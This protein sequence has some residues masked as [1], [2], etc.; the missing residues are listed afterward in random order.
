MCLALQQGCPSVSQSAAY[1][2]GAHSW[3]CEFPALFISDSFVLPRWLEWGHL[4]ALLLSPNTA[5]PL[6]DGP[7]L[8]SHSSSCLS[9]LEHFPADEPQG[10]ASGILRRPL[11]VQL[12]PLTGTDEPNRWGHCFSV[13]KVKLVISGCLW[14][15]PTE[16]REVQP[17]N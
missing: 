4:P 16:E 9:S 12:H 13:R 15:I 3:A 2:G 14:W 8:P 7:R 1:I 17:R 10:G 11:R 5:P 6:Q